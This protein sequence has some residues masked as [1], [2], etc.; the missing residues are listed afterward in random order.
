M[1]CLLLI[2]FYWVPQQTIPWILSHFMGHRFFQILSMIMRNLTRWTE[3]NKSKCSSFLGFSGFG[4]FGG[5]G[6][7]SGWSGWGGWWCWDKLQFNWKYVEIKCFLSGNPEF[8]NLSRM[9]H[10][11]IRYFILQ[12]VH[13]TYF[14]HG[15]NYCTLPFGNTL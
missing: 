4:G 14:G 7:F 3:L 2:L 9:K 6:G 11:K 1:L 15:T 10:H 12:K 5:T 8:H 13:Q